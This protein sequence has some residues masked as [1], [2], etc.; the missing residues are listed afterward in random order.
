MVA[1]FDSISERDAA[2][3]MGFVGP[4]AASND[5]LVDYLRSL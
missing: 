3:A 2:L 4:I 1:R 5:R